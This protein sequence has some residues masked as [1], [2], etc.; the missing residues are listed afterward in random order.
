MLAFSVLA[1]ATPGAN[2]A[3]RRTARID[4][5]SAAAL[6]AALALHLALP[7]GVG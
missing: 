6:V 3:S 5:V 4:L 1:G 2:A 7:D